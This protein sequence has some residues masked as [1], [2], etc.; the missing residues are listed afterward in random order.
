M[1][2]ET[3]YCRIQPSHIPEIVQQHL[4]GNQPVQSLLHPR[5]HPHPD[6]YGHSYGHYTE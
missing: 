2:D 5:F 3:W 4:R 1:P 6:A